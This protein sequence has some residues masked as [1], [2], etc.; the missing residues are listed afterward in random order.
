MAGRSLKIHKVA[1][2]EVHRRYLWYCQGKQFLFQETPT[3]RHGNL[4]STV[5]LRINYMS[6]VR[7]FPNSNLSA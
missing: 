7:S 6:I 4:H 2:V 3:L 1:A 5:F